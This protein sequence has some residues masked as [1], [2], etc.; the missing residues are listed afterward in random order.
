MN[1]RHV[2]IHGH[3]LAY[4][5]AGKGPVV[6]LVHGMASGSWTWDRVMP[7][8]AERF[9]AVAPDLLGHG[10]SDK[11]RGEYLL[12]AH[13]NVL[14]HLLDVLRHAR[15]TVVGQS[16]G[17]GIATQL[18]YQFP[19]LCERLVLVTSGGLGSEV[20]LLLSFALL[21]SVARPVSLL[22]RSR[23]GQPLQ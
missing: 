17:G 10:A 18:A 9:T 1:L 20:S 13:A 6:L 3:H 2:A 19:E 8:L 15:A 4:H 21:R 23:H 12:G 16:L 5:T 11:P 7:A 22:S 14:R